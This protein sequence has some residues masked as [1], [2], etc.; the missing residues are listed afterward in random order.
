[1]HLLYFI[2]ANWTEVN[3]EQPWNLSLGTIVS[4]TRRSPT[5]KFFFLALITRTLRNELCCCEKYFHLFLTCWMFSAC[6]KL[7]E[8]RQTYHHV[9]WV[10][11]IFASLWKHVSV[12]RSSCIYKYITCYQKTIFLIRRHGKIHP[13]TVHRDDFSIHLLHLLV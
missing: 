5:A 1:M 10:D 6:I 8:N 11:Q 12:C 2:E 3:I 7:I 13:A 9:I 4:V